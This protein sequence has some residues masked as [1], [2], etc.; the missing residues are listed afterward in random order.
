MNEIKAIESFLLDNPKNVSELALNIGLSKPQ[1]ERILR[2]IRQPFPLGFGLVIE[3]S[4]KD[5]KF[6]IVDFGILNKNKINS[7]IK[8]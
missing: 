2:K 6:T 7:L 4:R 3:W 5:K 8:V 1:T